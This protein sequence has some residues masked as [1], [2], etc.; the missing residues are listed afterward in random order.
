M[1]LWLVEWAFFP[2]VRVRFPCAPRTADVNNK[3]HI[4]Q[5][6]LSFRKE[7]ETISHSD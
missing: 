6:F 3:E 1:S 4:K 7:N 5:H 2:L